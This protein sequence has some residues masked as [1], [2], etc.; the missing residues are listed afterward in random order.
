MVWRG[1]ARVVGLVGA[2]GGRE[3]L[4]CRVGEARAELTWLERT[5]AGVSRWAGADCAGVCCRSR[6]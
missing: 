2:D 5:C 3:G 6:W 4:G 1:A